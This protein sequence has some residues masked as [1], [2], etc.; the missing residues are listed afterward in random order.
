M[1]NDLSEII[2]INSVESE[3][4]ASDAP[5][6]QNLRNALDWFLNKASYYGLKVG[7][8][9]GYYGWA[10]YGEYGA[11]I[12]GVPAHIDI[13]PV[14]DGWTGDPLKLRIEDGKAYGRGVAD[15]KGPLVA[16]L[17]ALKRLKEEKVQLRHR[18]RL[19][20]GCNEESGSACLKKYALEDEIPVMSIV[21]DADFPLINSEKGILHL[22]AHLT[23]D[24]HFKAN[25]TAISA[26][27]RIN[28]VPASA[29]VTLNK[30]GSAYKYLCENFTTLTADIFRLP[31]VALRLVEIGA[32]YDDFAISEDEKSFTIIASGVAGHAMDP[33]KAD[34]ALWKIFAV[35]TAIIPE[36]DT[37]SLVYSKLCCRNASKKMGFYC[38]DKQSGTLTISMDMADY[39]GTNL[40]LSFDCR[41]PVCANADDIENALSSA[42]NETESVSVVMER[43]RYA[44]NLFVDANT[45]MI[46]TLLKVYSKATGVKNPKPLQTGGGTYAREL[47]SAVAFGPTFPGAETNIHNADENM[48][49]EHLN[50]L[51]DIYYSAIIELDK[52]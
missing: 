28:V 42:L 35:L 13:V 2:A 49:I 7:E 32:D 50:K 15:D 48:E 5:F 9:D 30:D 33:D 1:L 24:E 4:S 11:P 39:D 26:S 44:E 3:R 47:P 38:E 46:K 19:I 36:S 52:L 31:R 22:C 12:I 21:P 20:V 41:L 34:N 25:I 16:S 45:P 27:E 29:S 8:N 23:A 17:W 40:N 10:E 51:V 18:V 6:G 37:L 14:G 43:L